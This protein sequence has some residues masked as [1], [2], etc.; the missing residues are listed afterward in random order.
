MTSSNQQGITSGKPFVKMKIK[1]MRGPVRRWRRRVLF[2]GCA[3]LAAL[4]AVTPAWAA[5]RYWSADGTT[6]GGSGI[7]NTTATNRWSASVSGP[8]NL[9]WNNA[10]NDVAENSSAT[11]VLTLGANITL[12]GFNQKAGG[13]STANRIEEGSGPFTLTLGVTGNNTFSPFANDTTGRFLIINAVIA[14]AAGKNL[15]VAGPATSG[16]GTLTLNRANTF[17]GTTSF[18]GAT[19]AAKLVL[20]HPLALQNSTLILNHSSVIQFDG[21]A[22][23]LGGLAADSSG[24][25]YNLV[26]QSG[27]S[28]VALT[29]GNN[30]NSTVYEGVF[31]GTGSLIKT[32]SGTLNLS[33]ASTYTGTTTVSGGELQVDGSL[34]SPTTVNSGATLSGSGRVNAGVT[35][36]AGGTLTAGDGTDG[37]LTL[38]NLTFVGTGTINVGNLANYTGTAAI[39][40]SNLVTLGGGVGAVTLN[41]PTSPG[42]NGAYH[43]MRFGTGL[44]NTNGFTLGTVPTLAGNQTGTLQVNGNHLD[45]VISATGDTSPPLLVSRF[46]ANNSSNALPDT[47]LVATFNETV[48]AGVGSIELR[49][50][51]D[52]SLVESFN[53]TSSPRLSFSTAQLIIQPTSNLAPGQYYVLI[54]VGSV[55]DTSSNN[56]AGITNTTGWRFTVPAPVVLYTDTGS[57]TNPPWSQILPTLN[58]GSADP[59]PVH[60]SVINVNNPVVEVGLYGNRP[61]SVPAQRLHVVC[62][63]S[64]ANFG[65]FTRWFQTD[66]NTH[67]VRLFVNDENTANTRT[68]T[69]RTEVF[70]AS[71][72]NYA[73]DVTF[74]WTGRYTVARRQQGYAIFQSK[75]DDNDWSVQLNL[76]STGRLLVNNRVAPDVTVTN[77]DGSVKNFDGRGF[78]VR[79]LDDG[80]F[81]RVWVDGVLYASNSYTRPTGQTKF[82]WGSYLGASTLVP[83]SDF[84]LILVSGVQIK[85]WPGNLATATTPITKANNT[86]SLNTGSSWVGGVTPGLY[87]QAL[88]NSTVVGANTTTLGSDQTWAGLRIVNPGGLVTIN[89]SSILSLDASGVDMATATQNLVVNCPVQLNV[90]SSWNIGAG[91]TATFNGMV[92]GY[93][94]LTLSGGGIVLLSGANVYGGNT[95]VSNGTLVANHNSALGAGSL[96]LNGGSL[97][98]STSCALGNDV[99]LNSSATIG[100]AAS[101]NLTLDGVISGTNSLTKTGPGT[102][103]LS[104]A[105]SYSDGTFFTGDGVLALANSRAAG[106]GPISFASTQTGTAGTFTLNGGIH[107]T[108]A[109]KFDA[110]TGRN[111]INSLSAD[112][113]LSGN[114]HIT[115]NSGNLIVFNNSAAA[116]SGT[117]F[118][119]GGATPNSATITAPTYASIISFRCSSVGN[120]GILNSQLHAPNAT[121]NG[122]N[123][124]LWRINSTGNHWAVTSFNGAASFVLGA[125]DALA[126]GA[127]LNFAASATGYL[128][129]NGK[130][131]TVA[132]LDGG[133]LTNGVYHITNA[134]GNDAILTLA[135]LT[136]NRTFNGRIVDGGAGQRIALVMNSIGFTQTLTSANAYTGNT[137]VSN[138]TLAFQVAAIATNSTVSIAPGA[139]LRLDF[140]GTNAVA[141]FMTNGV[142]LA[143]GVYNAAN[144]A[145]FITGPG[146]LQVLGTAPP[147]Q[148]T[149]IVPGAGGSFILSGT[150][151]NGA[152]YRIFAATNLTLPF[153]NWTALST[154]LFGGGVFNFTDTQATNHPQRFYRAVT[155]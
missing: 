28:P 81:Y 6:A 108:N 9:A 113:T 66:G 99:K 26:L 5:T 69:A 4:C 43:L 123:N 91:R 152:A 58:Q 22:F 143:P 25:G 145:P 8:W 1:I 41:L 129:L 11:A 92:S 33:G 104:A 47:D 2:A 67:V 95:I 63:T 78:D 61:I 112:N 34:V 23:T 54:P 148:F 119:V 79:V 39:I 31:S 111:T 72:W 42:F 12:G 45:Y 20:G 82:R 90:P 88:W 131:Q 17:A 19:G 30:G 154:G 133:N 132:G 94:G 15:L 49:R 74:E 24:P 136:A 135:G 118:T 137:T 86:T 13:S 77:L 57:P 50:G 38:S 62:N 89:G 59:G 140:A 93:P 101:Q 124:G 64:T 134:G 75:N 100:V 141:V 117:T 120:F 115:N 97:S 130:N 40:V 121:V 14:G 68:N 76:T 150:G 139:G 147:P 56:F 71:G 55:R 52:N 83:P 36:S 65:N 114:I 151:P 146:S 85:S 32:G 44:A 127:P 107:V 138:G 7:W 125:N 109:I 70:H 106:A 126:T 27:A 87:N 105:N 155:P 73:D 46:P 149:G 110:A 98:N 142:A 122:N 3:A 35:V 102:L 80:R 16:T 116:G 153:S 18:T 37:S 10:N 84:N 29:V 21:T 96:L 144:A 103:T 51:S 48:M 53:V 60:G 128:D